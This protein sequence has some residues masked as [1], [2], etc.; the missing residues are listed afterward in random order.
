MEETAQYVQYTKEELIQII[1]DQ[2]QT[3]AEL[4]KEVEA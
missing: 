4:K 2:N 3:I 1:M